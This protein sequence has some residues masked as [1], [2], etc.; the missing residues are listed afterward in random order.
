MQSNF[1]EMKDLS[2]CGD[3]VGKRIAQALREEKSEDKGSIMI[4]LATDVPLDARQLK[5]VL[6]RSAVGLIRTGSYMGHGSG[7]VFIGFTNGN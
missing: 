4:V 5:R 2:V 3:P 7:D 6:K 1:G